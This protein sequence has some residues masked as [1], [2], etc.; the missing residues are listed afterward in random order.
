MSDASAPSPLP[1]PPWL[2]ILRNPG[3]RLLLLGFV[4]FYTL[5]FSNRF[6]AA[7]AGSP[8]ATIAVAAGMVALGLAIYAGFVRWV[9]GRPVTELALSPAA[10]ELGIGFH[11][12]WNY[13]Q[14]AV[15]SGIVSGGESAPGLIRNTIEGPVLLTGGSFGIEAPLTAFVFCTAAGILLLR[16]AMRRGHVVPP[17]WKRA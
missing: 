1:A 4:L 2:R 14:S 16:M 5:G 13:T 8:L 6:M 3:V 11:V 15:F 10:R 12:S 17:S 9:E 7:Q